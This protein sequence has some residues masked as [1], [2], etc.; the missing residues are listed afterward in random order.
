MPEKSILLNDRF[1]TISVSQA[2]SRFSTD[3]N[4]FFEKSK[5]WILGYS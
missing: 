2:A 1:K 3:S 4:E 5:L